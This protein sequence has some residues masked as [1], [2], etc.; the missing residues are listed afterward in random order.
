MLNSILFSTKCIKVKICPVVE[1]LGIQPHWYW[2]IMVSVHGTIRW[3]IVLQLTVFIKPVGPIFVT[4]TEDGI[5][6][7]I[8]FVHKFCTFLIY[9][10]HLVLRTYSLL[11]T[12][13]DGILVHDYDVFQ[14]QF[15]A[16][17]SMP[18][19]RVKV[20]TSIGTFLR[21][22]RIVTECAIYDSEWFH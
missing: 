17:K 1:L 11:N 12:L 4:S 2:P 8:D 9:S 10:Y 19:Y 15:S 6:G 3:L 18:L 21:Q 7:S 16:R 5:T 14:E 13:F 22:D 20:G